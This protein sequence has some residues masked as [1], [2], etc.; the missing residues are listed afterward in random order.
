[1]FAVVLYNIALIF[2]KNEYY[3][4]CKNGER[5]CLIKRENVDW[6]TVKKEEN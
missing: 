3:L 6:A 4:L 2:I 5:I 1:M